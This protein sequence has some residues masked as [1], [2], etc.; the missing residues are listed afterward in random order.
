MS[1]ALLAV[2]FALG[3]WSCANAQ[4]R[5]S[6]LYE[7]CAGPNNPDELCLGYMDAAL[8]FITEYQLWLTMNNYEYP[9]K[10]RPICVLSST[11]SIQAATFFVAWMRTH[12]N[13]GGE[14]ANAV[15]GDALR[16]A[17]ACKKK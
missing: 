6:M 10:D 2:A 12:E 7:H 15:V 8:D 13:V 16:D 14:A 5:A 17:H 11:S 4:M 1:K 9:P 3:T